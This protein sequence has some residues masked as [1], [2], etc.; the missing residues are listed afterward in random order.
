MHA[1]TCMYDQEH[2]R[3]RT[4]TSIRS[5]SQASAQARTHT[6][7]HTRALPHAHTQVTSVRSMVGA[8]DLKDTEIKRRDEVGCT[9][10]CTL[11]RVMVWMLVFLGVDEPGIRISNMIKFADMCTCNHTRTH[12][13]ARAHTHTHTQNS[14]SLAHLHYYRSFYAVKIQ[15]ESRRKSCM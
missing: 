10:I 1:C 11:A 13:R 6:H 2:N 12:T 14:H 4:H 7:V 8:L 3:A 5:H 15:C 9:R